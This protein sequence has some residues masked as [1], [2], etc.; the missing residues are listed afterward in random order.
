[1][2]TR[3]GMRARLRS[4][5]ATE[6]AERLRLV[7]AERPRP[8]GE[9]FVDDLVSTHE[10]REVSKAVLHDLRQVHLRR[11]A[12]RS[13]ACQLGPRDEPDLVSGRDMPWGL[14]D[15]EEREQDL[16]MHDPPGCGVHHGRSEPE[17]GNGVDDDFVRV[18][19]WVPPRSDGLGAMGREV[20]DPLI[21]E[22]EHDGFE[23]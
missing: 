22:I 17:P 14:H 8:V 13:P 7:L 23:G 3:T 1:M 5:F 19:I 21:I 4:R 16:L 11:R 10:P 20:P 2:N 6:R 15:H 12:G 18:E 9:S